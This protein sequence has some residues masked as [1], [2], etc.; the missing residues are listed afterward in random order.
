MRRRLAW[1]GA[2]VALTAA[3]A[4][5]VAAAAT[6]PP[7]HSYPQ[8]QPPGQIEQ[9]YGILRFDT[10]VH[11]WAI[12]DTPLFQ[13]SG[14]TAV[15]CAPN[16]TLVVGFEP[17]TTIG[18]FTVDEDESYAG[19]YHA[20]A[21][22][23]SNAMT[24]TIRKPSTGAVVS[25]RAPELQIVNS[26]LQ[27]WVLGTTTAPTAPTVQPVTTPPRPPTTAPTA[28][29]PTPSSIPTSAAPPTE[30]PIIS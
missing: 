8:D 7:S 1:L 17:L 3:V 29:S 20:G 6:P 13:S 12:L 24:I 5:P 26:N 30:P 11:R 21:S 15:T 27:V 22:I 4:V 16:G 10:T 2:G 19:R 9:R 14:L 23:V 25:C 28:P 18:T